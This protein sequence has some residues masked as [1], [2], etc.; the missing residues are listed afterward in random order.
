MNTAANVLSN[1]KAAENAVMTQAAQSTQG[2]AEQTTTKPKFDLTKTI[3]RISRE[4]IRDGIDKPNTDPSAPP[5]KK[6]TK[7]DLSK[8]LARITRH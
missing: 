6:V 5:A 1:I 8:E 2:A 7:I 3:T 4:W